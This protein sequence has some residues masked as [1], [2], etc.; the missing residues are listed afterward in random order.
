MVLSLFILQVLIVCL[1]AEE[2]W[3]FSAND[4]EDVI[5][6]DLKLFKPLFKMAI[7]IG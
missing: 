5:S 2:P 4:N 1:L 3:H 6:F 7:K